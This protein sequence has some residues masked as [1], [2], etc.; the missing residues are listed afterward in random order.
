MILRKK[1]RAAVKGGRHDVLTLPNC[2]CVPKGQPK[3][4]D[5]GEVPSK[6]S[7]SKNVFW[8]KNR[9][10]KSI[11]LDPVLSR[12]WAHLRVPAVSCWPCT[13]GREYLHRGA[14]KGFAFGL[15]D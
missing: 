4:Q 8:K 5:K 10:L 2:G 7:L 6:Q 13:E 1:K 15:S 14:E 9:T 12:V 11:L 3:T